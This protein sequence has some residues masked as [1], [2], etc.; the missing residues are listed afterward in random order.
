MWRPGQSGRY[1]AWSMA[2]VTGGYACSAAA[3]PNDVPHGYRFHR[4]GVISLNV[5]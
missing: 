1:L 3:L 2:G 4:A 5:A